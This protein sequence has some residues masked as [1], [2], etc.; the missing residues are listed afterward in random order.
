MHTNWVCYYTIEES[1]AILLRRLRNVLKFLKLGGLSLNPAMSASLRIDIDGK[2]KL[3]VV[4]P[5]PILTI[6]IG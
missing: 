4:N 2:A 5:S 6:S 1:V 3:W